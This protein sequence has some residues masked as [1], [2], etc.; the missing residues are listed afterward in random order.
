MSEAIEGQLSVAERDLLSRTIHE[1]SPKPE[2]TIEVGTWLGGGSTLH[3]L[4][5]LEANGAG[6]L[7]GVEAVP[8]IYER[9]VASIRAAAPEAAHRFTPLLGFS[10]DVLPPWLASLRAGTGIDFAFL[11]GGDNPLEQIEEWRLLAPRIRVGGVVMSHDAKLRKGKW[12]APFVSLLDNWETRLHDLSDEGLLE[13][14]K[15][16]SEP[17]PAS[18]R[19]AAGKLLRLRANPVELAGRLLPKPV[20][21]LLLRL[22]PRGLRAAV[23]QGRKEPPAD[24]P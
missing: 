3:I 18:A 20:N 1:L 21:A 9:M 24:M 12:L 10:T 5:A 16:R 6:H 19:A 8:D 17:S 15:L 23:A 11:D 2:I 7:W 13:A 22:L 14:R 4:R